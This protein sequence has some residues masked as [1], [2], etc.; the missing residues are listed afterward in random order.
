MGKRGKTSAPLCE[1]PHCGC[2]DVLP[3]PCSHKFCGACICGILHYDDDH[4]VSK[5]PLC[6]SID[7][8]SH[9]RV[10]LQMAIH[11]RARSMTVT[12]FDN[13][14]E[15]FVVTHITTTNGSYGIGSTLRVQRVLMSLPHIGNEAYVFALGVDGSLFTQITDRMCTTMLCGMHGGTTPPQDVWLEVPSNLRPDGCHLCYFNGYRFAQNILINDP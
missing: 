3:L 8:I 4:F 11:C 9:D 1:L 6:R 13:S 5:C 12:A 10:T 2:T 15:Q 14:N 7:A